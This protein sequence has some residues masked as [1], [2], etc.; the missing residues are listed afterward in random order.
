MDRRT[1]LK[2]TASTM[3]LAT[4]G[5]L[6]A[7]H[8]AKAQSAPIKVGLL[9]PLTGV[10]AAG[11]REMVDG[12]NMFWEERGGECA[13]RKVEIIVEDDASNPDTALQKARRLVEQGKRPFPG[14]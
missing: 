7:P 9:A 10:V 11:G 6:A 1:F 13:G 5:T 4:A 3:A 14:R 2:S 8:I 12:F